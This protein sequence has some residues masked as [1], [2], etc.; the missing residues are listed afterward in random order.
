[1]IPA[2][3]AAYNE[4]PRI[5][6]V[7][8]TLV[9]SGLFSA[10]VVVDDGSSDGTAE[11]ARQAGAKVFQQPRNAGKA[12]AMRRGWLETG[13]GD[14]AFFDADL[15]G[16]RVEHC[17]ALLAGY[18]AGYDQSCGLRDYQGLFRPF[19]VFDHLLTGERIVRAWVLQQVPE[20]CWRG[21]SIET[22]INETCYRGGGRSILFTLSGMVHTN[23]AEKRGFV[24]G[25]LSD[26][27]MF[28]KIGKVR[29]CLMRSE[30]RS[31]EV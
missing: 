15:V 24:S 14:V 17:A 3:I 4:A 10:V 7:V 5:A 23:K 9:S 20:S 28:R 12:Q 19:H 27:Q 13:G 25:V 16:L 1:M 11:V 22:A 2:V 26:F 21:F 30:G 8:R 29:G 31:C 18:A 6:A